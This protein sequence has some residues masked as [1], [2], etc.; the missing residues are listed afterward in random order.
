MGV[1]AAALHVGVSRKVI[2]Q[3]INAGKLVARRTGPKQ[4]RWSI[5]TTDLIAWHRS[6][7]TEV[8]PEPETA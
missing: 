5:E 2:D 3:A 6:L 1:P 8:E 7:P 4:G